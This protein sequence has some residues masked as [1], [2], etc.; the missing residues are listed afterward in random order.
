MATPWFR[1][2]WF[3][4]QPPVAPTIPAPAHWRLPC[5]G[6]LHRIFP[7][8]SDLMEKIHCTTVCKHTPIG[9]AGSNLSSSFDH[10][11]LFPQWSFSVSFFLWALFRHCD[12]HGSMINTTW[13][14]D[15]HQAAQIA[16]SSW[17]Q[18]NSTAEFSCR[19][20]G[21]QSTAWRFQ[22]PSVANN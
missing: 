5:I 20:V 18:S 21:K 4:V 14:P 11:I 19:G 9:F 15:F 6:L 17:C 8:K 3:G 2:R 12:D 13:I 22:R 7:R 10:Y 16:S 1:V